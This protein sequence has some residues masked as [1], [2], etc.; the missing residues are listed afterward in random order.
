MMRWKIDLLTL[1]QPVLKLMN[2]VDEGALVPYGGQRGVDGR[3]GH[4][5]AKKAAHRG[6]QMV[7]GI[8]PRQSPSSDF[9]SP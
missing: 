8:A 5:L 6:L 4:I 3:N 1:I 2:I 7:N 9:I